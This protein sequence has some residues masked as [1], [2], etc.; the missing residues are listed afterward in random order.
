MVSVTPASTFFPLNP[1]LSF[2]AQCP[3]QGLSPWM[4]CVLPGAS[5]MVMV[6][7]R[8]G[9]LSMA[10]VSSHGFSISSL[11][12]G[13]L[14]ALVGIFPWHSTSTCFWMGA[15]PSTVICSPWWAWTLQV[16]GKCFAWTQLFS[17]VYLLRVGKL[18]FSDGSQHVVPHPGWHFYYVLFTLLKKLTFEAVEAF[19][20]IFPQITILSFERQPDS[21]YG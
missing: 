18:P 20:D 11:Q 15:V 12:L 4:G 5:P 7:S 10:P 16:N 19:Q 9:D 6:K 2:R 13:D 14:T 1:S 8:L 17:Y 21:P 3:G